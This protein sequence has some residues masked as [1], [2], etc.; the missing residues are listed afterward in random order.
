MFVE[1]FFYT[2]MRDALDIF[3]KFYF[4]SLVS[5]RSVWIIDGS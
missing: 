1:F 2:Y 3:S 5:I 4:F